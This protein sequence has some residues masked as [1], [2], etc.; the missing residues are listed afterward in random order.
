MSGENKLL[1]PVTNPVLVKSPLFS[2]MS[3]LEFNAITA[4]LERMRVGKGAVVFKEG[5]TGKDM[6]ILLAGSLSAFLT[7]SDGTQR[8][9]FDIKPGDFF[10]EM[11][12]I[13]NEPRSVTLIA[14]EDS[15]VMVLQGI[16]FYRIIFEHPM[17][18]F[19]MLKAINAVQ[20]Q[21]LDQSSKHLGDLMRWGETARR[22]A[23][24]DEL[25]GLYNRRFL[26]ESI[27]DRFDH[28]SV[29][30]R[31]MSLLMMDIDKVH[32]INER[33][34][35]QAGDQVI[36][37]T[38]DILRSLMR[39]GDIAARLSGD[40]FAVLLPDTDREDA[41]VVAERIREAVP[42]QEIRVPKSPG[43]AEWTGINVRASI[44]IAVAP[45]HAENMESLIFTADGA[46]R[47]AKNRGRNRVEMAG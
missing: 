4:F 47:K 30:L 2:N 14:K 13:A 31:K 23:I 9:L 11:S 20:N 27:A 36:I 3:E 5:D 44:G 40:E 21:W 7:Q 42:A 46:L 43:A 41:R 33:H 34:G 17:I 45:V 39:S 32:A 26:E 24:T 10:G 16:D 15:D 19:K 1:S 38:A 29:G 25:T 37:A 18:G 8:W 6:F 35:P 12:I 22:R 28:G